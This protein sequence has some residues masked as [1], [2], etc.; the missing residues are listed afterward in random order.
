MEGWACICIYA[1]KT[2]ICLLISA[3]R[4]YTHTYIIQ[5]GLHDLKHFMDVKPIRFFDR[6]IDIKG[7]FTWPE[8][9]EPVTVIEQVTLLMQRP[10]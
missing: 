8:S 9:M 2:F 1:Q 7:E 4:T 5:V 10:L 3:T 6:A